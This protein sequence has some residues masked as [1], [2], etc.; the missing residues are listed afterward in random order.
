MS[1]CNFSGVE[2]ETR[3][4][5]SIL[6]CPFFSGV[7]GVGDYGVA[8]VF[9]V[10]PDLVGPAGSRKQSNKGEPVFKDSP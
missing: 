10:N 2:E 3:A 1:E 4:P 8:E 5:D 6:F 9:E 7:F